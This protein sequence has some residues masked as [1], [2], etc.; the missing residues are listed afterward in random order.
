MQPV[1]FGAM[2][3]IIHK[4]NKDYSQGYEYYYNPQQVISVEPA[5][6]KKASMFTAESRFYCE[7]YSNWVGV[8]CSAEKLVSAIHEA[9]QTTDKPYIDLVV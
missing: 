3:R 6:K 9:Q 5:G 8:D 2:L 7:E 1:S 4:P